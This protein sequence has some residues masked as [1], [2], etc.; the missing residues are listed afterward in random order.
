MVFL[1][2]AYFV[3]FSPFF[4]SLNIFSSNSSCPQNPLAANKQ[5]MCAW[6][7]SRTLLIFHFSLL[8]I[9][10]MSVANFRNAFHS[11]CQNRQSPFAR[12]PQT[13]Q[14]QTVKFARRRNR[15]ETNA[16]RF[17]PINMS[18][19]NASVKLMYMSRTTL[20][21]NQKIRIIVAHFIDVNRVLP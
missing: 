3:L 18:S 7:L 12:L 6:A 19:D 16:P 4:F 21:C 15:W 14:I 8:Y 2:I 17:S 13:V 20:H 11:S 9:S 5:S 1:F 10:A